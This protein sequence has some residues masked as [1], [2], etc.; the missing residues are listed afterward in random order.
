MRPLGPLFDPELSDLEAQK[1]YLDR[2]PNGDVTMFMATREVVMHLETQNGLI[3]ELAG[4]IHKHLD[5]HPANEIVQ[6]HMDEAHDTAV[7]VA[8]IK[9]MGGV[10]NA[11]LLGVV[12]IF[13]ATLTILQ[14]IQL[15]Q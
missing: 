11:V 6:L 12:S 13:G 7:G 10:G 4:S 5:K 14:I 2:S 15:A 3:S 1:L 9:R 8:F